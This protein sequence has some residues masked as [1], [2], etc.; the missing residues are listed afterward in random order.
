MW[1]ILVVTWLS[2][3]KERDVTILK[4]KRWNCGD[5]KKLL[6][7]VVYIPTEGIRS[8]ISMVSITLKGF[9]PSILLLV[10]IIVAVILVVVVID[11]IVRVVIVVA[12]IGVVVV[13]IIIGI[14]VIVDGGVSHI[15]KLSFV[16]IG[17][18]FLLGLSAF[19]MAAAC[20]SRAATTP[21]VIS[22]WMVASVIAGVADSGVV[23]LTGHK[24]PSDEDGG[25]RIGDSTRVSVSLGEIS[26]EGNKSWESNI[27]DSDNT[28][29]GGKIAGEKTSMSKRYL[30]KSFEE[31]GEMLPR[32]ITVVILVRDRCPRGK[33]FGAL[34]YPTKDNEDLR[35]VQPTIDIGIFVGY[36][37]SRKCYRIYNK[38]TRR[39]METIHVQFDELTE[40]MACASQYRTRSYFS[41]AWTD[42][43]RARTKSGS[44]SSLC[45]PTNKDLEILFQP[46]F[47][48]Y[49][50]PPRV[51]RP[52]SLTPVVQAPVNSAG[53][54]HLPPLIKMHLLQCCQAKLMLLDNATEARLMLLSHINAVKPVALTSAEQKLSR[55]NELKACSTLLM[56]LSNKHQLKFNSH[57]DAKTLM[58][59][60]EKR[61]GGNT[62]TK[63]VQKTLLKQQYKNFTGSSSKSLDQIHDRMQKLTHTLIWRNK[64]DLEKHSLDD[65]FNSLKIYEAEVKHSSSTGAT[66][67][68]LAFVSS[69]NT[70]STTDSVSAAASVSTICA[71]LPVSSL[72]NVDSL[73]NAVIYSFF[74]S[75][76]T[77]PQ[78]DNEDLKQIDVYD[79]DEMDL[80]WQM[81]MLT[82]RAR[83][84]LQK[85]GKNLGNNGPTSMGFDMSKVECYNCYR[86]GHFARECRSP[87]DSRMNGATELQKRTVPVETSTSNA[88]VSQC[89]GVGCYDWSYQAEE[90]PANFALMDFSSSSSSS[91]N[92]VPSCLKACSKAYTQS[93]SQ[94]DKLTN[95]FRKSQFDVIS[96]QVGLESIKARL[97]VYKQNKSVFKENI[98]LLNIEVQL[99]DTALITL[100]RKLEKAEQERDD[101]KLKLE[102]FLTSSKNLTEQLASQTNEKHGL[103]YNSQVFPRETP[104]API[105]EDWVSDFKDESETKA[106]QI[107]PSFVQSTEQ[108]KTRRN[109]I[110]PVKTS[111]PAA[112]PKS[113]SPKSNSRGKRRNRKTCFMCKSVDHLIKDYD[114][115]AK[116]MAQPIPRNYAHRG[117]NKQNA[118][119]THKNPPK[120]MVPAV[121]LTQSKLV[122]ITVVRPVSA[123]VPKIMAP[124]VS[125]AQGMKEK[126]H[127]TE[128]M[129]YLSDFEELNGGYVSFRGNPKGGKI[130]GIKREFS[131]PRTLQQNGITE[132]KNRTLIEAARTMLADL[133]LPIPFWAEA[134]NTACYVQNKVLVTKPHNKTPY[135]LLHGRTPSIGFM[136]PFGCPV[137]I[138][139]TLDSLGKFEG[140]VDEGFLVGYSVN[141]KA[142]RV[143]NSRTRIVRETLHVN[144]LDSKP[145]IAGSNP[146]WLFDTNSLTRTMNYQP[147]TTGNQTN[148]SAG[149]QDKF[150]AEKTREEINQQYVFFPV[151]SSEKVILSPSSSAQSRKQDDKTKKEAKG[152][153]L[154]ESFTR[155]R[156]LSEEFEYC[157]KN[158]S[159]EVNVAE[160]EDITYSDNENDVD[161]EADFNNLETSITVS[162]I[163][164]TRIHKDHPVPQ[165]I[166]DL[167]S[168]TQTRSMTRVVKD[169]GGTQE[170]YLPHGK[171]A[172]GTKWVYMNKKDER[173]IVVR[174]KARLVAQ[175]HTQEE[176][177]DYEEDFNPLA[178]IEAIRLFLAYAFFMGFMVY[179]MDVKSAFLYGTIEEEVYVCQPLGFEDPN[180]PDKVYKVVKVLYGLHQAPKAWYET[181]ANY[182]LENGFQKGKIDQTLFIKKQK[183]DIL[184]VQIY[185]DDIIFGLQVKQKKDGI[186]ISQDKYVAEILR[187]F[188][189]TERKSASTPIDTEKPLLKDPDGKDV[190][191]HTYRLMIGSL[192]Y[193]TSSRPDIM[194][195]CKKQT[196][197][198]TSSTEAEYVPAASC[199]AQFWNT[200]AI[201][202]V[203][204]VTWLQA[205]VDKKKVV[206][207]EA[208]IRKVLRLDD[209][210]GVDFL[211]NKEIFIEMAR[212]GYENPSTKLTFY[213]AFFLSQ[214]NSA[215]VSAVIC[216]STGDDT[217]AHGEVPT[218]SQ[219]PSIP[220]P[221]PPTPPPKL[222]QDLPSTSQ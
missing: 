101:L 116:K 46:M 58:E 92:E 59:T 52:V 98:K 179:Q 41:N 33:V 70:D 135:E 209:A 160:L 204:D 188:R 180:H 93:H 191:V 45:T 131:V 89:D 178:R 146:I 205:L 189:L 216:L 167:S 56:A 162:L 211:P 16:I 6:G 184:L 170:V 119:L 187:K 48:E 148:S 39:I 165:I 194:F 174:N 100:R 163:P 152:K 206:V 215:M 12:S 201:K 127:M 200:V 195:A 11:V 124:V 212:M 158:S 3:K 173:G 123:A 202:H 142:F 103:G 222:P 109:S 63:K 134:V 183:G 77:S 126:W 49:V 186:F 99:R 25:T 153:I 155:Y 176:G 44:C 111:I 96:Y 54:L 51:E 80:K 86:K 118:S 34:C 198:A 10:V 117:N 108:V 150:D 68:N 5:C 136:R 182:L 140:K 177:I 172:I 220:S 87:K 203:N 185:V 221:T 190:D 114:Y 28:G 121:V 207:T 219:E 55:K 31:S 24:D 75:Q 7:K 213:K 88:L 71:K 42:K 43:F 73:S 69:S 78:L 128:N 193:L 76:S 18:V 138:L 1:I 82:M 79:L 65:L 66:T 84:F 196:V 83:R 159:I 130:S 91:D 9:M 217:A 30:V 14:V 60:I 154:V 105:I 192:M 166:G 133:L 13:V 171:R 129:S 113:T 181:L 27:G 141:S 38:R 26:L 122:S 90:E 61:F 168:T 19:A 85:T 20:A 74:A 115:H 156:D 218:V 169:Q 199:C 161:A 110:Q 21:F 106:P 97:L 95:D 137:T 72:P 102:K 143:F 132:R 151:W 104:I 112:T 164:T 62:K 50:E 67:Q 15:I 57:K 175:R 145:N 214:W 144:F 149:F 208:A 32:K 47:D 107:I 125:A 210:E 53:H 23:D 64:V 35:K 147:V 2:W 37:P 4:T 157:S 29:D 36:A 94:Y 22:C 120:Y 17:P 40:P 81:A 8:I 139:N 197:V